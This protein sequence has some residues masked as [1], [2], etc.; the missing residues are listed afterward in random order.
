[1]MGT[2][3]TLAPNFS[4]P[5]GR[6]GVAISFGA[7][8]AS[9]GELCATAAILLKGAATTVAAVAAVLKNVRRVR[10]LWLDMSSSE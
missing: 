10:S 5:C 1:M 6:P 8:G 4:V 7:T 2:V 3:S 9:G